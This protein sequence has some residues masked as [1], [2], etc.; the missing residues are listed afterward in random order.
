M[1]TSDAL[2][3]E[4]F[5]QFEIFDG[6][7]VYQVAEISECSDLRSVEAGREIMQEGGRSRDLFA[8]ISGRVEVVKMDD[9]GSEQRL[10]EIGPGN[11]F[12]ELGLAVGAPRTAT[13]RTLEESEF[14]VI[15]GEEFHQLQQ[16][17]SN[18]AYKVEHNILRVVARRMGETNRELLQGGSDGS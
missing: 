1:S 13:V 14:L 7:N 9:S 3:A 5:H 18:A 8:L 12:G 16:E 10:A 17:Y 4:Q 2:D 11:V 6:L 15:D